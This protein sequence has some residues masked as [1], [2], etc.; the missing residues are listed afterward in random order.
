MSVGIFMRVAIPFRLRRVTSHSWSMARLSMPMGSRPED[1][2]RMWIMNV[3]RKGFAR[4]DRANSGV[5][6]QRALTKV[7][8]E[9]SG[10]AAGWICHVKMSHPCPCV[11]H[12]RAL[13]RPHSRDGYIDSQSGNAQM[14]IRRW[15][16][17]SGTLCTRFRCSPICRS[18]TVSLLAARI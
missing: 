12:D 8:G 4:V 1:R 3:T 7:P 13:W 17:A 11:P 18:P 2:E 9:A 6:S 16:G 15:H 5:Q 14:M 10:V